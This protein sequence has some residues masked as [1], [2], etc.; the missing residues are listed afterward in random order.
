MYIVRGFTF[1]LPKKVRQATDLTAAPQFGTVD[2]VF[3]MLP[4]MEQSKGSSKRRRVFAMGRFGG[5]N[6]PSFGVA[7]GGVAQ[8]I[9]RIFS[10]MWLGSWP[11]IS[12]FQC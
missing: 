10:N 8:T 3:L 1:L 6:P 11:G 5:S 7:G 4:S 2:W 9:R 12:R